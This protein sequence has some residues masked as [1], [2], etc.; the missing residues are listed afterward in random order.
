[1]DLHTALITIIAICA[2]F[3]FLFVG[4]NA[5][6]NAKLAP[7]KENQDRFDAELKEIKS[8]LDQLLAQRA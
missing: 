1:M 2:V 4:F 5:L 8:K 6:L 7:L 3:S